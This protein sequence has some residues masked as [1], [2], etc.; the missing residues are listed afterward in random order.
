[1]SLNY[2]YLSALIREKYLDVL[3]DNIFRKSHYLAALLKKKAREYNERKIV[4]PLEYAKN[5]NVQAT[6][7][8]GTLNIAPSDEYTAAEYAP[9]MVTGTLLI[10]KEDELVA[11]SPSAVRNL[12]TTK[13]KSLQK[14]MEDFFATRLWSRTLLASDTLQWNSV[15]DLVNATTNV[16]VG[17][18]PASGATPAWWL[19]KVMNND[20]FTGN[21][22]SEAD[23]LDPSKD[24]YILRIIQMGIA[25]A[26]YL[27]GEKPDIIPVSQ[28]IYDLIEMEL[29]SQKQLKMSD[30]AANMGFE[31]IAYRGADI[32]P[33]DDLAAAQT[34]DTDSRIYFLNLEYLWMYF[35]KDAKFEMGDFVE[36]I[37]V[38]AKAA[39]C[40]V[41]GNLC[42]SN[43]AA[44]CVLTGLYSPQTYQ[45]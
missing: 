16:A 17:G 43:R 21:I 33:D 34:S 24:S 41:Y 40:W 18:I 45:T 27:T 38:G 9:K 15:G 25:K 3:Y 36:A 14:A 31:A 10:A 6:G 7:K 29:N 32:V 12:I 8:Y 20:S 42:I 19:S 1:M 13:I 35:N 5:T 23:L 26:K 30:R 37:N 28:Y 44:Q 4:V 22:T 11:T 39:K 2:D